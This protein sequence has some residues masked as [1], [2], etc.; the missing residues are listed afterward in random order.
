MKGSRQRR[1]S[2][3]IS[4]ALE[5]LGDAW[6]LLVVRDLMFKDRHTFKDLLDGGEGIASNILADRLLRLAAAGIVEKRRD[7]ADGRRITYQLTKKGVALA[8]VLVELVIWSAAHESSHAPAS[9]VRA[10]RADRDGF[11]AQVRRQWKQSL[12]S[13]NRGRARLR[14][15]DTRKS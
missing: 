7:A 3:P 5:L 8:P 2:C 15:N 14:S 6:S 13:E 10:M 1:S 11:V 12:S 9:V 4:I